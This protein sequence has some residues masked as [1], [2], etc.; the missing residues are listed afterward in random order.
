MK[1][2][3][4]N[5]IG[6]P[7]KTEKSKTIC[8]ESVIIDGVPSIF[9]DWEVDKFPMVSDVISLLVEAQLCLIN[10]VVKTNL[11]ANARPFPGKPSF[12]PQRN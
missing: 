11:M 12:C 3:D 7:N 10:N 4:S 1:Q 5:I 2:D 6:P 8:I 9:V